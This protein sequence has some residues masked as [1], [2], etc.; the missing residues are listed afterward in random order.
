MIIST[1]FPIIFCILLFL[2]LCTLNELS[3]LHHEDNENEEQQEVDDEDNDEEEEEEE[4]MKDND[5]EKVVSVK[6]IKELHLSPASVKNRTDPVE[7]ESK[8]C[9]QFNY[10]YKIFTL[11]YFFYDLWIGNISQILFGSFSCVQLNEN[12]DFSNKDYYV[13]WNDVNIVCDVKDSY[14]IYS[15]VWAVIAVLLYICLFPVIEMMVVMVFSRKIDR[16]RRNDKDLFANM[17]MFSFIF[18]VS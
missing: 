10:F 8:E 6:D 15:I 18:Q 9:Q 7:E 2:I 17:N 13:L 5:E 3:Y 14:Y 16:R 11:I 12:P 1:L 4:E